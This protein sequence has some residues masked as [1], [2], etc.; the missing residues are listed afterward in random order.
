MRIHIVTCDR[1]GCI[2]ENPH[3]DRIT[4][5]KQQFVTSTDCF[6]KQHTRSTYTLDR[7]LHLCEDCTKLFNSFLNEARTED[8]GI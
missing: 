3:P 2:I 8:S 4:I 7:T 1:C 5:S 6:G